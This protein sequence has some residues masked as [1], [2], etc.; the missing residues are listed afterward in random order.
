MDGL[1][2]FDQQNDVIYTKFND[3]MKAKLYELAIEQELVEGERDD[4][5]RTLILFPLCLQ[6]IANYSRQRRIFSIRMYCSK[7]LVLSLHLR[8]L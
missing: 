8:G 6:L 2:I 7:Y 3:Q 1:L 4:T 5:V